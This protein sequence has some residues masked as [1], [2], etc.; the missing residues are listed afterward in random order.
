MATNVTLTYKPEMGSPQSWTF[1]LENPPWDVTFGT[2]KATGLAWAEFGE[3][4]GK[5]SVVALRALVFVLRKRNEP[6]L[7]IDA[8]TIQFSEVELEIHDPEPEVS[9]DPKEN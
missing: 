5:M 2:E 9:E 8:V 6:R 3:R 4:L 7:E 1:D